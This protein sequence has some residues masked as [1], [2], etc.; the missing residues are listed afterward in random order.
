[1]AISNICCIFAADYKNKQH[2]TS[3]LENEINEFLS[4]KQIVF[5]FQKT[6]DW[7]INKGH[8]YLDFYLPDYN[9]AIECHGVQHFKPIEQFGGLI[10]F[11][12]RQ[13]LDFLKYR[14]CEENGIKILYYSKQDYTYF[15]KIY[16]DK[17]QLL[18]FIYESRN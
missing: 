3:K 8:L 10:G 18:N 1:M 14:L 7:L 4:S 15:Q 9:I 2:E 11:T 5:D 13:E 16:T 12:I 6:F 17:L